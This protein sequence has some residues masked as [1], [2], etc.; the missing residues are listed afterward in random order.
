M[1]LL[2]VLSLLLT[3]GC[4]SFWGTKSDWQKA[5]G[6]MKCQNMSVE[7]NYDMKLFNECSD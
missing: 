1:K 2:L 6:Y 4:A 3:T 5:N 7:R